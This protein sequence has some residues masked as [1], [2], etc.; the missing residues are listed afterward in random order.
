[1]G[2]GESEY[3]VGRKKH[4]AVENIEE[5]DLVSKL[6]PRMMEEH[7]ERYKF[8]VDFVRKNF[9]MDGN[10][11]TILNIASARGYGNNIL[12]EG[13]PGN[14]IIG[15]ELG[16]EYVRKAHEKYPKTNFIQ[17]N[18]IHLPFEDGVKDGS[19]DM[20]VAFEIAEHLPR[21]DQGK[22]LKEISRVL[23]S[24]GRAIVS[25]PEPYSGGLGKNIHHLHE[26]NIDEMKGYIEGSGMEIVEV[27]GQM[28]VSP[29]I[30]EKMKKLNK[31][32]AIWPIFAWG[33]SRD[34]SVREIPNEE[35]ALTH[36]FVL[37]KP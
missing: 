5:G 4:V 1:M 36:I 3:Q 35:V 28:G 24:G 30:A 14:R 17:A 16:G 20:A 22:L 26:P 23:K 6:L 2:E 21:E 19:V 18:A 33:P 15:I 34:V 11:L 13:L 27:L 10:K 12:E 7:R 9:P 37:S 8:T 25:V 29:K 32:T 31:F